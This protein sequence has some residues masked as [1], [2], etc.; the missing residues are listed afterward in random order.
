V[1]L[2]L[3]GRAAG[4]FEAPA[5]TSTVDVN[6]SQDDTP[7]QTIGTRMPDLGN[8]H[9]PTGQ[10]ATYNSAPPTSG[11]H[12][13]APAAPAP[14]GI[15][16]AT[17]PNEVTTHDLEHGTIVVAYNPPTAPDGDPLK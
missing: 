12:W 7:G 3:S 10:K 4:L 15:K 6:S 13:A 11:E 17:L 14:A 2:P 5:V 16:D 1:A 8:A 9:I